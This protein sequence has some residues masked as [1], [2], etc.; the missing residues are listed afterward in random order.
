VGSNYQ[1]SEGGNFQ[2]FSQIKV[3]HSL[4]GGIPFTYF[5]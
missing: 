4:P 2:V 1:C 3:I 5:V